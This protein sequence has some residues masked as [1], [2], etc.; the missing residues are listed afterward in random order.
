MLD[1]QRIVF[2]SFLGYR[3]AVADLDPS[4]EESNQS[5]LERRLHWE[6]GY[7]GKPLG[8]SRQD[9]AVPPSPPLRATVLEARSAPRDGLLRSHLGTGLA[10]RAKG[11]VAHES[12]IFQEVRTDCFR[13]QSALGRAIH[14]DIQ[15]S[16]VGHFDARLVVDQ[17]SVDRPFGHLDGCCPSLAQAPRPRC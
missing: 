1:P 16:P 7:A 6:C 4:I 3:Q 9:T 12:E 15:R 17:V 14:G 10:D 11:T 2:H 13:S 5:C 8:R